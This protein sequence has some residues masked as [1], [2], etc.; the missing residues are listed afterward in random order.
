MRFLG[1]GNKLTHFMFMP[2]EALD[3]LVSIFDMESV[4]QIANKNK[5]KGG[6]CDE[7]RKSSTCRDVNRFVWVCVLFFA[8]KC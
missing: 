4:N 3:D 1:L 7:E 6:L 8:G 5:F 2:V